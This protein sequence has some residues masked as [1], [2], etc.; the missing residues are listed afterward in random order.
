MALLEITGLTKVFGGL[1]A[2]KDVS[3]QVEKG[4][5]V[6]LIG[7]N[8]AGKTT[9]F[10][11]VTGLVTPT[12]GKVIFDGQDVTGWPAYKVAAFGLV[13]TFQKTKVFPTLTVEE[14]VMVGTHS[15]INTSTLDIILRTKHFFSE[16]E[17]AEQKV[18]EILKY[19]GL[20]EKRKYLC[21]GLSYGE[22]RILEIAVALAAEPK[23]LLL[24]EPAAGLNHTESDN[25]M[26]MIHG[27]VRSGITVLLIEH[28]MNLVMRISDMVAVI[29]FGQRIAFGTP[30][31]VS[32]NQAVIEAYLGT[33]EES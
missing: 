29:N 19:T 13:T 5:I 14:A 15:K 20:Y 24:D 23:L 3:F 4:Q 30:E 9:T 27:L 6:S 25:L 12:S 1:T 2:V 17:K 26:K 28:D 16:Q 31:E 33:G 22:Q 10:S 11:M 21:T 7:P 8:G 32:N 18:A